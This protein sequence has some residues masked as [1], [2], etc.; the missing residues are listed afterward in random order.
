MTE[1]IHALTAITEEKIQFLKQILTITENQENI[2]QTLGANQSAK[3][4]LQE[5]DGEKERLIQLAR[6][7]DEGFQAIFER[8]GGAFY[9][10]APQH[11]GAVLQLQD[12]IAK[13]M[14]LDEEIRRQEN[15]NLLAVS[16]AAHGEPEWQRAQPP[17]R[18]SQKHVLARYR[19]NTKKGP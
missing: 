9:E 5:M 7:S 14:A 19:D 18:A 13:A 11:R 3:A 6:Q 4:I 8:L 12:K 15:A 10:N 1:D 2:Y 16:R 17:Q